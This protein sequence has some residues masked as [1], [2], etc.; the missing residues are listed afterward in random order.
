MDLDL[1]GAFEGHQAPNNVEMLESESEIAQLRK[2]PKRDQK[3]SVS[4]A[5]VASSL[6]GHFHPFLLIFGPFIMINGCI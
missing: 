5:T 3:E 6:P 2:K 4:N 1:F